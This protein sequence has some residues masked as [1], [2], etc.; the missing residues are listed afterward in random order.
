MLSSLTV[1][2]CLPCVQLMHALQLMLHLCCLRSAQLPRSRLLNAHLSVVSLAQLSCGTSALATALHTICVVAHMLP[3]VC[4]QN[5]LTIH[6]AQHARWLSRQQSL[7]HVKLH[8]SS[9]L[10]LSCLRSVLTCMALTQFIVKATLMQYVAIF[11]DAATSF[12]WVNCDS[13]VS[14]LLWV[15]QWE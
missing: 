6:L 1:F 14:W 4:L 5:C 9:I 7:M 2:M 13:W 8:I 15:F 3:V 11:V 10:L 12:T